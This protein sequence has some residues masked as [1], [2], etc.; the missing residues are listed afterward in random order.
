[1]PDDA[2]Q[3]RALQSGRVKTGVALCALAGIA[4]AM[5]LVVYFGT[6]QVGEA[7]LAA[8]WQG[9]AAMTALYLASVTLCAFAWQI[10]ATTPPRNAVAVFHWARLLRDSVANIL[11]IIPGAGEAIAAR[12]LTA[13]GLKS[14]AAIATT[15]VDLTMEII[16]QLFFTLVGL[17]FLAWMR[18]GEPLA[19][20]ALA[21]LMVT[22]VAMAGFVAA[23]RSGLFQFLQSLPDRLGLTAPWSA[24]DQSQ[25]IHAGIEDIYREPRRPIVSTILHLVAWIIGAGE[26]WLALMFMGYPLGFAEILVIESLVFALRTIA[27]IVPWAAGVQ[28]GGYVAVGAIFGLTPDVALGLSLLKRARELLTGVPVLLF[29]QA[30]EARRLLRSPRNADS[31]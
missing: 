19:W 22:A 6:A 15:V 23:Q 10:L 5:A 1:M 14:G 4:L 31:R 11:A 21:G 28:E 20:W 30:I 7:F 9:L 29:W 13:F 24:D 2:P 16:S 3:S 12:E 26:A 17:G 18:P 27:F 25:N 8:G